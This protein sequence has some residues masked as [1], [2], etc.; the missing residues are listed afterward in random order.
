ML[1]LINHEPLKLPITVTMNSMAAISATAEKLIREN[2]Q[3]LQESEKVLAELKMKH[4]MQRLQPEL[5]PPEFP[6]HL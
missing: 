1:V 6:E 5:R 4:M 2:E 3:E